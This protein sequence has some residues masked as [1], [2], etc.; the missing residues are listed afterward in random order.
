M[1]YWLLVASQQP[2]PHLDVSVYNWE[3]LTFLK[4]PS[5]VSG[6]T[7]GRFWR[8]GCITLPSGPTLLLM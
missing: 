1:D 8:C 2:P 5:E 4:E 7:S 6:T 3:V